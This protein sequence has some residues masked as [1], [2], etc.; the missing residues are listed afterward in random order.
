MMHGGDARE[1]QVYVLGACEVADHR[2]P[3]TGRPVGCDH[4]IETAG[5][6]RDGH[7]AREGIAQRET[8]PCFKTECCY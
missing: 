7:R 5:S 6:F 1:N 4:I 8:W 2:E 3:D